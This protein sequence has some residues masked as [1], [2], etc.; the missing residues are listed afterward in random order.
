M[1]DSLGRT[2]SYARISV[3]DRCNLRC[4]YCMGEQGVE[5]LEHSQI[6][7]YE[8]IINIIQALAELGINKIRLTGGEPLVR[9]GIAD[10]VR[11]TGKIEGIEEIALTTNGQLLSEY[12][13]SLKAAGL[14]AINISL[15]TLDKEKYRVITGG[16]DITATLTG[17]ERAIEA[18][19]DKI[20]INAVLLKGINEDELRSFAL[21]G[22]Q[23]GIEVRF[24]ELMPFT[25]NGQ[26]GKERYIEAEK[27]IAGYEGLKECERR[28]KVV[29][30]SFPDG[31]SLGFILP[32]SHNFCSCCNRI[33]ITSDGFLLNCLLTP[34]EYD[35]KGYINDPRALKEYIADCIAKKPSSHSLSEGKYQSR[36]MQRIG[37]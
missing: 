4:A 2:I 15:D 33:R 31:L 37:G 28:G 32:V 30:F 19:F 21:F 27:V 9:K 7:S 13:Q 20:K 14:N 12:A 35:L 26:Y 8:S 23:K 10:L 36:C 3:T 17:I 29:K 5:K 11:Q 25:Q 24:I 6:L 18:G 1:K 16:G 22:R 34:T